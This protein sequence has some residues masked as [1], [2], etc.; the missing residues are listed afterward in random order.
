MTLRLFAAAAQSLNGLLQA[1]RPLDATDLASGSVPPGADVTVVAQRELWLNDAARGAVTRLRTV[2]DNDATT[3]DILDALEAL[4]AWRI[5]GSIPAAGLVD[6]VRAGDATDR[7]ALV[8][9]AT[10]ALSHLQAR[11]DARDAITG[12]DLAAA[13][14][15][16]RTLL[17]GALVLPPFSPA[18]LDEL[19]ESAGRCDARVG[20]PALV[21]P[22]LHQAGG[23]RERVGAAAAAIDLVE[24]V[25]DATRFEPLLVQ[26]PDYA[27][28][29]WIAMS[30]PTHDKG[31][32]LCLL[33]ITTPAALA[34]SQAGLL[35]DA[36]TETIPDQ[37][38]TTGIA[39]HFDAPSAQAPQALLLALAPAGEKWTF[40]GALQIV[41]Q[42]FDR[43][44]HRAVGPDEIEGFG[45]YLPAIY[46]D[47]ATD[48]G[49][50][51]ASSFVQKASS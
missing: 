2:I 14:Q 4:I 30:A 23:V 24:S 27:D 20:D 5:P 40:G 19:Q 51:S 21:L 50:A 22:W 49:T 33:S 36:W 32:R 45:Q 15:R 48:P 47:D 31:P 3:G 46:L 43:A 25:T 9:Q 35:L 11:I 29:G 16:I 34:T 38:T 44:R 39:V 17:P 8:E 13:L 10:H 26:I 37:E 12:A 1:S 6:L 41:R 7:G 18:N 42:T 28:E